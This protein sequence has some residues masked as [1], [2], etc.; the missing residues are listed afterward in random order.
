MSKGLDKILSEFD[1]L[2]GSVELTELPLQEIL[3]RPNQPRRNFD[4]AELEEL[5][6]SIREL[7][8]LQPLLVHRQPDGR[9]VLV[10]GER[11]LRAAELAGLETVPVHI[12]E[13]DESQIAAAALAENLARA[14]LN[15]YERTEG[16]LQ[17]LEQV[18]GLTR[19][20]VVA[21]VR[22][23]A[24]ALRKGKTDHEALGDDIGRAVLKV[25]ESVG[26]SLRTFA[27]R[28]LTVLRL[29]QEVHDLLRDGAVPYNV[30]TLIARAPE[31]LRDELV[32]LALEGASESD[33]RRT[34]ASAETPAPTPVKA[35][36]RVRAV[37]RAMAKAKELPPEAERLIEQ[38][39]R[40]LGLR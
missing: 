40:L 28:D 18:L 3:P 19:S 4:P 5:A 31:G 17:F 25:F 24:N 27:E 1:G 8:V 16:L 11:R 39:E 21:R 34:I 9:H 7:G 2:A 10:A 14:D 36:K 23:M 22:T 15:P 13:G 6:R 38:L 20:E 26:Y 30:A 33:L 37:A 12:F 32:H 29:P 35:A